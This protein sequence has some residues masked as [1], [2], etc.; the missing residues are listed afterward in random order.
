MLT[1]KMTLVLTAVAFS[2][3]CTIA[4]GK[5][6]VQK[7]DIVKILK[8]DDAAG[9]IVVK[10]KDG[11]KYRLKVDSSQKKSI[12]EAIE[13]NMA[14]DADVNISSAKTTTITKQAAASSAKVQQLNPLLENKTVAAIEEKAKEKKSPWNFHYL[15][16]AGAGA[17]AVHK[18]EAEIGSY[19][20]LKIG[21][22]LD[23]GIN[24]ALKPAFSVGYA[25]ETGNS[26]H[27]TASWALE[28]A[29]GG[30]KLPADIGLS[31]AGRFY[32][33]TSQGLNDSETR[34]IIYLR[35]ILSKEIA[36]KISLSYTAIPRYYLQSQRTTFNE[37]DLGRLTSDPSSLT[38]ARYT[39]SIEASESI[40]DTI[41][42]S[43]SIGLDHI[44][45]YSDEAIG[46]DG[47]NVTLVSFG[48]G[49]GIG[50]PKGMGLGFSVGQEHNLSD[51][52]KEFSF[53]NTAEMEYGMSFFAPF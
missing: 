2:A 13:A 43:Q 53:L 33:P 37:D 52:T 38:G 34:G 12:Q 47:D 45:K 40:N 28:V 32:L 46:A 5:K 22:K 36:P 8:S 26:S 3:T 21:Y 51:D 29:K 25:L 50:L 18:G 39:H 27:N 30:F 7:E 48:V 20:Q 15:L 1:K 10:T 35:G 31:L 6:Q 16:L 42:F 24:L 49:M 4:A 44:F 19:H 14:V 23:N 17:E 9:T 41:S 11:S